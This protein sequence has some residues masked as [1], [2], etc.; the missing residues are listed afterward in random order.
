MAPSLSQNVG[1]TY[2]ELIGNDKFHSSGKYEMKLKKLVKKR[3]SRY[4]L[5]GK[6]L[7]PR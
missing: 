5:P 2:P 4:G 3:K 7:A 1:A 6:S